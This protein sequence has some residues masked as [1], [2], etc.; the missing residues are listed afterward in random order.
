MRNS[1][2]QF[3]LPGDPDIRSFSLELNQV[4]ADVFKST[5]RSED[6]DDYLDRIVQHNHTLLSYDLAVEEVENEEFNHFVLGI[7]DC[8]IDSHIVTPECWEVI[9]SN[10]KNLSKKTS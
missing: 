8:N 4:E 9:R 7:K 10:L 6:H 1:T 2:I 5:L 3:Y